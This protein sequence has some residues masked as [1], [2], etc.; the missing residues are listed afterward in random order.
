MNCS[1]VDRI[2]IKGLL[3]GAGP[4]RKS[5]VRALWANKDRL[6]NALLKKFADATNKKA[7][8]LYTPTHRG[9]VDDR[10]ARS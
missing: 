9:A 4:E 10:H 8:E 2:V 6:S 1:S 5:N 3:Q 7:D